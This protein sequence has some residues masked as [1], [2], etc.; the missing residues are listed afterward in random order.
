MAWT[1]R[2]DTAPIRHFFILFVVVL[3]VMIVTVIVAFAGPPK[4]EQFIFSTWNCKDDN[5]TSWSDAD[6]TGVELSKVG[7]SSF[8]LDETGWLVSNVFTRL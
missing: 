4:V 5:H 1:V 2:V 3:V 6:C 8:H 7:Y